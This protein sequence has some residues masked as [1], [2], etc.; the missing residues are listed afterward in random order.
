MF[1]KLIEKYKKKKVLKYINTPRFRIE[2]LYVGEICLKKG[3]RHKGNDITTHTYKT[4]KPK[5]IL[6]GETSIHYVHIKSNQEL[7][8]LSYAHI[9]DYAVTDV[10]PFSNTFAKWMRIKGLSLM[11]ELSIKQVLQ[12]E[13]ALQ[14]GLLDDLNANDLFN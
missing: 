13:D 10:V 6:I 7:K 4:V 9:E 11:S 8:D 14:T 5:A 12:L 2:D 1:K 3:C